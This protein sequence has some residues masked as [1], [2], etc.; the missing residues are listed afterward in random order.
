MLVNLRHTP[1]RREHGNK[2]V[3]LER[4]SNFLTQKGILAELGCNNHSR[5]CQQ[6]LSGLR[7]RRIR[8]DE[9]FRIGKG[10]QLLLL[11]KVGVVACDEVLYYFV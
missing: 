2:G 3:A 1:F 9:L 8:I 4:V 6:L 7:A 5:S 10:V 11:D